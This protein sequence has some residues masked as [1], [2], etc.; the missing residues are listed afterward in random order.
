MTRTSNPL[1]SEGANEAEAGAE[2]ETFESAGEEE[3]S[4]AQPGPEGAD[5]SD[6]GSVGSDIL[7]AEGRVTF[8]SLV[9]LTGPDLCRLIMTSQG[10]RAVCGNPAATCTRKNHKTKP[11]TAR[12]LGD[13]AWY[14]GLLHANVRAGEPPRYDGRLDGPR[15]STEDATDIREQETSAAA[16]NLEATARPEDL[17]AQGRHAPPVG[18]EQ[19]PAAEPTRTGRTHDA[20]DTIDLISETDKAPPIYMGLA[21]SQDQ[22]TWLTCEPDNP[23]ALLNVLLGSGWTVRN[24]FTTAVQAHT[25]ATT[26][27]PSTSTTTPGPTPAVTVTPP[28]RRQ[29]DIRGPLW[30][31][32]AVD[33]RDQPQPVTHDSPGWVGLTGPNGSR[34]VGQSQQE[35]TTLTG[36]GYRYDKC[37]DN[38]DDA[39][40]WTSEGHAGPQGPPVPP[41][42]THASTR[43]PPGTEHFS[44]AGPDTSTDKNELFGVR[45][46]TIGKMHAFLLPANTTDRRTAEAMYDCAADIL[47]LPGYYNRGDEIPDEGDGSAAALVAMSRGQKETGLHLTYRAASNNGLRHIKNREDLH[48]AMENVPDAWEDIETSQ[49]SQFNNVLDLAGYESSYIDLYLQ[50]GMLPRLVR[51]TYTYY[52]GLLN[53]VNSHANS[54]LGEDWAYSLAGKMLTLHCERLSSLRRQSAHYR[55]MV[56]RN[57]T[58]LRNAHANKY[59]DSRLNREVWKVLGRAHAGSGLDS[60]APAASPLCSCCKRKSAHPGDASSCPLKPFTSTLRRVAMRDLNARQAQQVCAHIKRAL[61]ADSGADHTATIDAARAAST[62]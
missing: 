17:H 58:Y 32:E 38:P 18:E 60:P 62:A 10:V 56:L 12:T 49:R 30:A 48:N 26:R 16:A 19:E 59:Y 55:E 25:W 13:S 11:R 39:S 43:V 52:V 36:Y 46:G 29:A 54:S 50:T 22:R 41:P 44:T 3:A 42:G 4:E 24:T 21:N 28:T 23:P 9:D 5:V 8:N 37:F 57:Y 34:A 45:I 61:A 31:T 53:T 7:D 2:E 27:G 47:A 51:D 33:R 15:F 6:T 20:H 35:V 1:D 14:M 40:R